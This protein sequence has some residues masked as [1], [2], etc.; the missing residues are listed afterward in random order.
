MHSPSKLRIVIAG[1]TG[2]LGQILAPHFHRQGHSVTVLARQVRPAPWQVVHW[3]GSDLSD[4]AEIVD[5]SDV[6][7]NLAGR[8]VDCRYTQAHRQEIMGS[9]IDSTRAIGRAIAKASRPPKVWLN[10]STATIYRHALD[11]PMDEITGEIGGSEPGVPR[12]WTFS[13]DVARNWEHA[14]FEASTPGTRKIAMRSAMIM[15][16]GPGAVFD[17]LLK[18]VRLGLGG[19]MGSGSQFFSWIHDTDFVRAID[20][21][22]AEDRL[23][24]LINVC[25]PNP[26]P[27]RDFMCT[28]RQAYGARL[29]LPATR[30]MLEIGA[31][32]LRTETELVLKSRRVVPKRLL[33]AG[34]KFSFPDWPGAANDLLDRWQKAASTGSYGI[35]K[36]DSRSAQ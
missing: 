22:I 2:H 13:I 21:L 32:F 29:G 14:F 24:G 11:R 1:G 8:S 27:Q 19:T 3:N 33:D 18:L 25:S 5:D 36:T 35:A 6:V 28:L 16:P 30:W 23:D 34:F 20:F 7:I 31:F 10:A 9:R 26:V 4:W 15:G 12:E 17:V